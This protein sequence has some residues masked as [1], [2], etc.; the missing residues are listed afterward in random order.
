MDNMRTPLSISSK[1]KTAQP[2]KRSVREVVRYSD[3]EPKLEAREVP[4]RG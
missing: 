1:K 2:A 4:K 3:P